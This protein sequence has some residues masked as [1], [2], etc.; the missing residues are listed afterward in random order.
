MMRQTVEIA[1]PEFAENHPAQ[2]VD[3]QRYPIHDLACPTTR[4]LVSKCRS[5]LRAGGACIL[6]G[7]LTVDALQ[8]LAGEARRVGSQ[9]H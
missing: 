6:P 1:D 7:F 9:A 2:L 5:A 4:A 8:R 3:L